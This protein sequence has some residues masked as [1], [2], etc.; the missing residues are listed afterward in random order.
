AKTVNGALR[1]GVLAGGVAAIAWLLAVAL[2]GTIFFFLI[3]ATVLALVYTV[4]RGDKARMGVWGLIAIAWAL[5][6]AERWVVNDNSGVIVAGAAWLGVIL[7]ARRAGIAKKSL[8][9]LLYPLLS[10]IVIIGADESILDPWGMSWLW[11]AAVL[12]PVIGVRTVL[13]PS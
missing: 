6:L 1:G 10:L 8:I 7:G 9:L 3:I 13:N 5:V 11:V 12:G 4:I 2:S